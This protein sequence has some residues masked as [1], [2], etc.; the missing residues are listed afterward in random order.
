M[1][2]SVPGSRAP[3]SRPTSG[4]VAVAVARPILVA[5]PTS[6][7]PPSLAGRRSTG[8]ALASV[9]FLQSADHPAGHVVRL[10]LVAVAGWSYFEFG[11]PNRQKVTNG[12]VA[13]HPLQ[14]LDAGARPFVVARPLNGGLLAPEQSCPAGRVLDRRRSRFTA[15]ETP[16][17]GARTAR[18]SCRASSLLTLLLRVSIVALRFHSGQH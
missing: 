16:P 6:S 11:L 2:A 7:G 13:R 14:G 4:A 10:L 3:P 17:L 9:G 8:E 12:P 1:A 5:R 15:L 18:F